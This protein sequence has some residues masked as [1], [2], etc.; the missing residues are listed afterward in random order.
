M[1]NYDHDLALAVERHADP[2]G[3][4]AADEAYADALWLGE[5]KARLPGW[6]VW[7]S[8]YTGSFG[9]QKGRVNLMDERPESL[10]E[11]C[12]A[13]QGVACKQ[14]F[15]GCSGDAET[16]YLGD[17]PVCYRCLDKLAQ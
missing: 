2:E 3:E 7:Q 9:A 10:L 1:K 14:K 16:F 8:E 4:R 17:W 5:L 6:R 15:A 12:R 11:R 13:L